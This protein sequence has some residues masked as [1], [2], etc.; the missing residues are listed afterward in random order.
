MVAGIIEM[1]FDN[2]VRHQRQIQ[3][4][5]KETIV[6]SSLVEATQRLLPFPF[7]FPCP[8]QPPV[9]AGFESIAYV[10]L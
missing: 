10:K 8:F 7:S 6:F 5:S 9:Q 2:R 1:R 4:V 3:V